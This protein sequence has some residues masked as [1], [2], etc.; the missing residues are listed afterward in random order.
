MH[1]QCGVVFSPFTFRPELTI[2]L[3]NPKTQLSALLHQATLWVHASPP[4]TRRQSQS[5]CRRHRHRYWVRSIFPFHLPLLLS[6]SVMKMSTLNNIRASLWP[7]ELSHDLPPTARI[8]GFDLSA[9]QYPP[10]NWLPSN[11]HLHVQDSFAPFPPDHIG[12]YDIVHIRFFFT[13][14]N[15]TN[16]EKLIQNLLT[17]LSMYSLPQNKNC[18]LVCTS[19]RTY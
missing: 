2:N 11:V 1:Q 18:H 3:Q 7:S 12:T 9:V 15:S 10:R 19:T 4:G 5:P 16:V 13:L 14:L 8:D 6:H 17:L